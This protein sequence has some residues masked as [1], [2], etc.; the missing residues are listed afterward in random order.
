[1][2]FARIDQRETAPGADGVCVIC[3]VHNEMLLLPHFL[4]HH[5]RLG[6]TS[7][8][9]ID[10]NSSDGTRE[11]LLTQQDCIVYH[12]DERYQDALWGVDWINRI[13]AQTDYRGWLIYVDADEH[14]AYR[15][16]EATPI[17]G[18]L[19][20]LSEDGAD[21][22]FGVMVDMYP[23]GDFLQVGLEPDSDLHDVLCWFDSDYV[24]RPWPRRPWDPAT[25]AYRLQVLGGPRCRLMSNLQAERRRGAA[26][27][28]AMNQVDRFVDLIPSEL[29]PTFARLWPRQVP[30]QQKKP[31]NLVG[32]GFRYANGHS[33]TNRKIAGETVA[34]LHFKLCHELRRSVRRAE[35]LNG[36][37]RRGLEQYQLSHAVRRWG[38]RPLTYAGSRRFRSSRDLESLGLIGDRPAALWRD[39]ATEVVVGAEPASC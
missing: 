3:P 10:N 25:S 35:T 14:L 22:V 39:G 8:V 26:H 23:D 6:V 30:A 1:M 33:S 5:R 31:I 29:M 7:F 21:T 15:D 16:M 36:H 28:T 32:P 11:Y 9:M 13:V 34:L 4:A 2:A 27:Y 20:R 12:T 38:D 17:Q 37:Y 18:F 19:R 24:L